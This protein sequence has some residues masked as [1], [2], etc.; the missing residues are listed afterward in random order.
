MLADILVLLS[1]F[2]VVVLI[3]YWA[4]RKGWSIKDDD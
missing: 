2:A 3:L 4:D 1:W